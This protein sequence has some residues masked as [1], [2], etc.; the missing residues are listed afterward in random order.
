MKH[1]LKLIAYLYRVVDVDKSGA[2]AF[3]YKAFK[4][5]DIPPKGCNE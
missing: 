3:F 1:K 4:Y 5:N 2:N